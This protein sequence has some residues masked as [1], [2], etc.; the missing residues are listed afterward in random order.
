[1]VSR[2]GAS[3]LA[4]TPLLKGSIMKRILSAVVA[5]VALS[6]AAV[7]SADPAHETAKGHKEHDGKAFPMKAETFQAREAAHEAK[8]KSRFETK[9]QKLPP[10]KAKIVRERMKVRLDQVH[11]KVAEVTK[12]GTVTKE[13]A[14]EVRKAS[15]GG[16]HHGK[17]R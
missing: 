3:T 17:K 12:D 5:V 1:M 10:E 2:V 4:T 8:W 9:I 6:F 7:A 15:H 13:E 16:K 11:A 14:K